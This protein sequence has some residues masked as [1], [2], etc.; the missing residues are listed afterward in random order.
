M[1]N[2]YLTI[3][4][5]MQLVANKTGVSKTT[6][7]R[8]ICEYKKNNELAAPKTN[9]NKKLHVL[10]SIDDADKTAIR[11][12]VHEF[13]FR[14]EPPTINKVLKAI[15]E[16]EYLPHFIRTTFYK[17]LKNINF[18][19]QKRGRH[20]ILLDKNEIIIWRRDYLKK[21]IYRNEN[22]KI[23]YLDETCINAGHTVSKVWFG[24]NIKFTKQAFL[25]D[26]STRLKN[27]SG[28]YI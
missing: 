13:F 23:Y 8:I 11:R 7:F 22:R 5:L 18:E 26:Y 9:Q 12:K 1:A 4:N 15:N 28:I 3:S 14:N 6:I 16:D 24:K 19:Y 21:I 25:S 20:S 2:P 27:P 17:L 10:D